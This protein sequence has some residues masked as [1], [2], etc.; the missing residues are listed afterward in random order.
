MR[1]MSRPRFEELPLVCITQGAGMMALNK[2]MKEQPDGR[3]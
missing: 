3:Q 2:D 1:G